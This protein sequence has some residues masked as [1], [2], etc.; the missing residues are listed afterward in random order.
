Y[1]TAYGTIQR[2]THPKT[3]AEK[4]KWEVSAHKF[5]DLSEPNYGVSLLNDC[6]YGH[7]IVDNIICITLLRSPLTPDPRERPEG[8]VN[9]YA[10]MGKH[11]F[12]YSLYPHSGDYKQAFS[13]QRAY[14]LNYPLIAELTK[15][16]K[17]KLAAEHS[18]I[19][20][21]PENLVLSAVKKAEDSNAKIIRL[22]EIHGQHAEAKL[23]FD[24]LLKNAWETNLLEERNNR[25]HV[26]DSTVTFTVKP[27]EIF[28]L[29]VE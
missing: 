15:P 21:K 8:Y 13:Y 4:A 25:L 12:V 19:K 9:P 5:V 16:H 26:V 27:F 14:E 10:D 7:D 22:Y 23:T 28:T 18:F 2:T 29:E 1:E 17:G 20:L 11:E 6:K 24:W 3:E